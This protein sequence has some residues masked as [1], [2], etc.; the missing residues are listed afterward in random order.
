MARIEITDTFTDPD[1]AG[2]YLCDAPDPQCEPAQRT[3]RRDGVWFRQGRHGM[4]Y[5]AHRGCLPQKPLDLN[6]NR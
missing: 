4:E 2:E 5:A 3:V 6:G 1:Y